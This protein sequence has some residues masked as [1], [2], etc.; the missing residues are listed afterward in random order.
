MEDA[1]KAF[2][3]LSNRDLFTWTVIITGYA[4]TDQAEK[5]VA[6]FNK[7]QQEGV[8]PNEFSIA[9]CLSACSRTA[10]LENGRQLHS[11][12][13]K[14]GHLEDLFVTGALVDMYAKCGCISDAEDIFEGLLS[15]DTVA[16]NIM[17]FTIVLTVGSCFDSPDDLV[18]LLKTWQS[19]REHALGR[20]SDE[21]AMHLYR[22]FVILPK[23]QNQIQFEQAVPCLENEFP[24]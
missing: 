15:R 11:M 3:R 23:F 18:L 1:V 7:M 21:Y 24:G 22:R 19:T 14:S 20:W 8:K 5:S 4:Q 6:C 12:V 16:W 9:G 13:I 2:N 17:N 10:V